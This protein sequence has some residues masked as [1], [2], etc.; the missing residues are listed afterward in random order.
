M[1]FELVGI[2]ERQCNDVIIVIKPSITVRCPRFSSQVVLPILPEYFKR[3]D[4]GQYRMIMRKKSIKKRGTSQIKWEDFHLNFIF[5][6]KF[7]INLK[8]KNFSFP[9]PKFFLRV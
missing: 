3:K 2:T 8:I 1:H 7:N 4:K 9:S 5:K 6:V